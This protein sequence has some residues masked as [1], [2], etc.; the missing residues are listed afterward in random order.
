ML[1]KLSRREEALSASKETVDI[2]RQFAKARPDALLPKLAM[3]LRAMALTLDQSGRFGEAADCAREGL[4]VLAPLVEA[5][6]L[7]FGDLARALANDYI[8]IYQ[9]AGRVPDR[10]LLERVAR[11]DVPSSRSPGIRAG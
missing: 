2:Y 6:P 3:S 4:E 8:A 7:T 10:A 1:W 9:K 11:G 5:E